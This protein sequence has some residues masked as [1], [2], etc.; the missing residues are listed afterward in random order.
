VQE[1]DRKA[2]DEI[3]A[4]IFASIDKPLGEAQRSVFWKGLKD[5]SVLEF[6]RIRDL[7][8]RDYRER[9]EPPRKF[10]L[11]DVWTAR[12]RLRAAPPPQECGPKWDGDV[13]DQV[14]NQQLL[15]HITTRIPAD[16]MRYGH[17]TSP[18]FASNIRALVAMKNRWA[19]LMREAAGPAG[20]PAREQRDC[21]DSCMRMAEE[22]IAAE[23][24]NAA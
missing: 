21:W 24:A 20:V 22:A 8:V 6:A 17:R 4:E 1:G 11:A 18:V 13:W 16:P 12:K 15:R 7:L 23:R 19:S 2:F 14:A 3:L 9:D 10:T 5:L